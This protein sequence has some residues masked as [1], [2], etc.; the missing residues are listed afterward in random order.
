MWYFCWF[1]FV[2]LCSWLM[3]VVRFGVVVCA[4]WFGVLGFWGF[5]VLGF[6][7]F[8]V[9][10][11][12]GFGVLGF[13]GLCFVEVWWFHGFMLNMSNMSSDSLSKTS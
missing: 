7:G 8:G 1:V 13:W 9:L 5:G 2:E 6:W 11:F 3:L 10:G 4:V 12:W